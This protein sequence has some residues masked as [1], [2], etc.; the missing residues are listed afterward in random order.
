MSRIGLEIH[1]QLAMLESKL[2]CPCR[3]DYRGMAPN[4]N[5]CP[6]CLGL[7][8]ALPMPNAGAVRSA[9]ALASALGCAVP[10]R[11]TFFRKNYFYPDLPKNYQITQLDAYGPTSVGHGGAVRVGDSDIRI[12]RVQLEEDPGRL[13]YEGASERTAMTLA[14]YNRAGTALV[15]I[16]TEPD[17][18]GPGRVRA[19]LNALSDTLENLGISEPG[20]EGAVRADGNVSVAEAR[21]EVK[22]VSSFHDLE[23]ALEYEITR[24]ESLAS[25]GMEIAQETRH[26]DER[27]RVTVPSR[28]KEGEG[29]YRYF[30]EGDIPWITLDAGA[31]ER[32]RGRMPEGVGQRRQRYLGYGVSAQVAD[33][34]ATDPRRS[35]LFDEARDG[36][37]DVELANMVATDVA[38]SRSG[39]SAA[40]LA[41]IAGAVADGKM[42]RSAARTALQESA[43]TGQ[44]LEQISARME[45]GGMGASETEEAVREVL[46]REP[47]ALEEARRNPKAVNYLVGKVMSGCGGR[48]DPARV[49]EIL[50]RSL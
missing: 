47:G 20:M 42:T 3:A 19:F 35:R 18:D 17:F 27:R 50:R 7:P 30:L 12:R 10:P 9:V 34:I 43:K 36:R 29:D 2:F 16:V 22:N 37:I 25:R 26:W 21:V 44:S 40:N 8:G 33:V 48:A 1:C 11:I 38:G 28:A 5:V 24:Q 23:K 32:I 14:D 45:L 6:V 49:L 41:K 13:V 4:T 15:E 46:E 39:V 31:V